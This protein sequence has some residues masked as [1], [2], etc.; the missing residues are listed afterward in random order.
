MSRASFGESTRLVRYN[1]I[2]I[3][4][5]LAFSSDNNDLVAVLNDYLYIV[6]GH[7]AAEIDGELQGASNLH[8]APNKETLYPY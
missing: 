4:D 5:T 8:V 7:V 3:E 6:G 1:N 2:P